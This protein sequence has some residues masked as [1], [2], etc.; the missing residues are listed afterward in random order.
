MSKPAHSVEEWREIF[1]QQQ[2]SGLPVTAFCRQHRVPQASF[3]AWRRKLR[4]AGSFAEVK[5][6][7]GPQPVRHGAHGVVRDNGGIELRLA[8]GRSLLVRAG[9]DPPTLRQLLA[10][11][12]TAGDNAAL[13]EADS[14]GASGEAGE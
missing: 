4:E 3:F 12:E 13:G 8:G 2:A 9:F 6:A 11:L 10:T 1:R 14:N 5:I 7:P